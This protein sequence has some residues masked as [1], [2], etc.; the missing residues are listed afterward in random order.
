M[1]VHVDPIEPKLK[2]PGAKRLKLKCDRLL[3]TCAFKFNLR[4]YIA[5]MYP[6]IISRE[7]F[8]SMMSSY[9]MVGRCRL[10]L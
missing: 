3:S 4:R 9:A 7:Y 10:P 5:A 8:F 6:N 2:A 1:P